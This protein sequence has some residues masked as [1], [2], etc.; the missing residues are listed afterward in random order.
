MKR[1]SETAGE[2]IFA[3]EHAQPDTTNENGGR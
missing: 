2:S 1:L 3:V